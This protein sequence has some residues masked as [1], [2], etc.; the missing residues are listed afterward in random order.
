MIFDGPVPPVITF[1][2]ETSTADQPAIIEVVQLV[3]DE[4]P[5]IILPYSADGYVPA[6]DELDIVLDEGVDMRFV[7]APGEPEMQKID[8]L[9]IEQLENVASV[10]VYL[11]P[12]RVLLKVQHYNNNCSL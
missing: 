1:E 11:L 5:Y 3:P 12:E 7:S 4:K 9:R 6:A 10:G 2:I 8:V